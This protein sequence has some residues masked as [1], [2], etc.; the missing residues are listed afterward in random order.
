MPMVTAG[1]KCAP[2]KLPTQYT[3]NATPSPQPVATTIPAG[4]LRL[5]LLRRTF[6]TTPRHELSNAVPMSLP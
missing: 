4:V 3:A 6:A 1:F 5:G 2:L